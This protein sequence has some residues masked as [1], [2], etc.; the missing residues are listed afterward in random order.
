MEISGLNIV[1]EFISE[2]EESALL[3][4]I[5]AQPWNT[6]LKRRTQHY[7]YE[8]NYQAGAARHVGPPIPEW[9][10]YLQNRVTAAADGFIFDQVIVNEY[11]PGQGISAHIDAKGS[12]ADT[13][14]SLSLGS[15]CNFVFKRDDNIKEFYVP[16][17][18]FMIMTGDARYKWTHA[19]PSRKSDFVDGE[20]RARQVRVSITWRKMK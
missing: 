19:I 7:G 9:L 1:P 6:S 5:N 20:R 8:Y 10:G 18:T 17:R 12:F 3:E 16:R 4:L 2:E 13:I 15:G 14:V 11:I